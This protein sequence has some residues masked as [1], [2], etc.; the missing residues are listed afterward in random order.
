M[1]LRGIDR[2]T[3][4]AAQSFTALI[5]LVLLASG[6]AP[7]DRPD[8]VSDALIRKLHLGGSAADAVHEVFAHPAAASTGAFSVVL[9]VFSGVSLAR[10]MQRLY[11]DAWQLPPRRGVRGSLNAALAL[12]VLLLEFGLLALART[13][14]KAYR[15]A[16]SWARRS[17]SWG[18]W[19][20][21]RPSRG[22][23]STGGSPGAG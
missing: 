9:L 10:R 14:V 5:P 23:F 16:G 6:L 18:A 2:G 22:S 15:P 4:I 7:A 1:A 12:A 11:Q 21:G 19:C 17:P 3:V 8:L 20:S 13:L